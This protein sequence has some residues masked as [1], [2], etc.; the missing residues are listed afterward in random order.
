MC[1]ILGIGDRKGAPVA[2]PLLHRM[3]NII[4]HRGPDSSGEMIDGPVGL[5][6]R[7]LSIIDLSPLG[8]QPMGNEDGSVV[9]VYNGEIYNYQQLRVELEAKGHEFHSQTDTEV[10]A[11][12]PTRNGARGRSIASTECLPSRSGI[13]PRQRLFLARDRYGIKPLY[14]YYKDGSAAVRVRDQVDS[15]TSRG[16]A[17]DLLSGTQ[18][19][20]LIPERLLRSHAVRGHSAVAARRAR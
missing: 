7:R 12:T 5:G 3:T 13:K 6:H 9:I 20:F 10:A 17:A 18:R 15:R 2:P 4:A 19:V 1:G 16:F 11:S 8:H 14:W